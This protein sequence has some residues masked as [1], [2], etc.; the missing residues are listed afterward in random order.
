MT[1]D[2]KKRFCSAGSHWTTAEF[3]KIGPVRVICLTCYN[4]RKAEL[5][6][7]PGNKLLAS[8]GGSKH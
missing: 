6:N 7:L 2:A 3:R 4:R 8:G 5:R 1:E